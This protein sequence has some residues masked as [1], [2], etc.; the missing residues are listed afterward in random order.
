MCTGPMAEG[1]VRLAVCG[2]VAPA[3]NC[4]R[5]RGA[6]LRAVGSSDAGDGDGQA[7][8]VSEV[9]QHLVQGGEFPRRG[10]RSFGSRPG[11]AMRRGLRLVDKRADPN[12]VANCSPGGDLLVEV[13]RRCGEDLV[14]LLRL[15]LASNDTYQN[16]VLPTGSLTGTP[17]DVF[18]CAFSLHLATPDI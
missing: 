6:G 15:Y 11:E 14:D 7:V 17:E 10:V 8:G 12:P 1:C 9:C 13:A 18:D 2:G 5:C 4:P 16:T 3:R